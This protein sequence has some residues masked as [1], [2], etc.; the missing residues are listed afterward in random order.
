MPR[1][2]RKA[3]SAWLR[4]R[5]FS[6]TLARDG[7]NEVDFDAKEVSVSSR[8][9]EEAQLQTAL[10]ECGHVLVYLSR[11]RRK[12]LPIAGLTFHE[13]SQVSTSLL[14]GKASKITVARTRAALAILWEENEAWKRGHKLGKRLGLARLKGFGKAY[15][16][17]SVRALMSYV[18]GAAAF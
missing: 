17:E 2:W 18:R 1:Q 4:R 12:R 10:H 15:R 7:R 9:S 11:R 16:R 13:W 6:L 5:G 14:D 8:V 3:V